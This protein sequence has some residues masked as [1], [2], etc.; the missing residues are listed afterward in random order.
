MNRSFFLFLVF[1]S[2]FMIQSCA[3]TQKTMMRDDPLIGKIINT[4]TGTSIDFDSLIK[5]ISTCDVIYL[6]EKHNNPDHHNFQER[7]IQGLINEGLK[8]S[9]GFEFFSMENTVDL[10]NFVDSG[11]VI[12]SKK[13]KK[14]I[15]ADLRRKL[16]WDTQPDPMWK[17]YFDLLNIAKKENLT[18]A[19]IDLPRN[20]K[21]RITRKGLKGISPIEKEL[22]FSTKLE[23][24]AYRDYMFAIF[25]AVHCG[26]GHKRMTSRLYDTWMAR[27]DK[28]ALS[29]TWLSKHRKGPVVIIIGGGHTEYGL[30]VIDRVNAIDKTKNIKQVNIALKEISTTPLNLPEYLMPL[31]LEGFNKVPPADFFFFTQRVSYKNPCEEF[32]KSLQKMKRFKKK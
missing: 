27:N 29:I 20:L 7:V 9:I 18:V 16:G 14:I 11:K 1:F 19:G 15:E 25:K 17:Y 21:R 13:N 22:V 26:M 24:K 6:S 10:L 30:G 23:D 31:E 8:P 5:D 12:H 4:S 2:L 3:T 28:M 32:Q